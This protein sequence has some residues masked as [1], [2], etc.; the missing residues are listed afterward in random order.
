M[1]HQNLIIKLDNDS[2]GYKYSKIMHFIDNKDIRVYV[3]YSSIIWYAFWRNKRN[4]A[5]TGEQ[6]S[7]SSN[8]QYYNMYINNEFNL[9]IILYFMNLYL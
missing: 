2:T 1:M 4:C 9:N 5:P 6:E 3:L 8:L 7:T